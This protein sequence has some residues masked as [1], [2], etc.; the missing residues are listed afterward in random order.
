MP[1]HRKRPVI[2]DAFRFGYD[3]IPDWFDSAIDEGK[4]VFK[5]PH[6]PIIKTLEGEHYANFGDWIIRGVIGELYPCKHEVFLQT[7]EAADEDS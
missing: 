2:I 5:T 4:V 6:H 1:R 7:Y 3:P